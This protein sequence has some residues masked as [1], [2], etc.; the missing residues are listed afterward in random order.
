MDEE[1]AY[2]F[3]VFWSQSQSAL[4]GTKHNICDIPPMETLTESHTQPHS[5]H[6]GVT[7]RANP[8]EGVS[9]SAHTPTGVSPSDPDPARVIPEG[10]SPPL[11]ESEGVSPA[12]NIPEG[13]SPVT[14]PPKGASSFMGQSSTYLQYLS[15]I[16]YICNIESTFTSMK[17]LKGINNNQYIFQPKPH[18]S[19]H[20]GTCNTST[21]DPTLSHTFS[22]FS[23][24]PV[25]YTESSIQSFLAVDN[26]ED[27]LIQGQMLHAADSAEF[28]KVQ[29]PEICG[30]EKMGVFQY[31]S[32]SNLPARAKLL[33]SIWS[34]HRKRQPTGELLK[35]KARLCV[36][37]SQQMYGRDFW[38]TYEPVVIWSAVCFILLLTT[39]LNLKSRQVDY[40]QAFLQADL[41]DPFFMRIPQGWFISPEGTID[42]H[43]DPNFQDTSHFIKLKKNLY[44]CKQAARNWFQYLK[45][46][47]LWEGFTQSKIDP[48]LYL[49]ADCIL[50]VYT[51]DCLIF[52]PSDSIIDD[53]IKN[54][55]DT[56][57]LEDQ[58]N[59]QDYLGI[60]IT[61]NPMTKSISM[62]QAGLIE[63]VIKDVGLLTSSNT[64]MTPP[65]SILYP[66]PKAPRQDPWRYRSIIG[67][68]NLI[69]QKT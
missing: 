9:P 6:A 23:D 1:T 59:V 16:S 30:L 55:Y 19:P 52:S 45:Q 5:L 8:D 34:Y 39:V 17:R 50:V 47:L 69:A 7:P 15:A 3:K 67:K 53:L 18:P 48:C 54:L 63:S 12:I 35:Y 33:S 51:D 68:L 61:Q 27:T 4:L 41:A 57:L 60:H 58:G 64:K 10:V 38:E 40:T 37:G 43:T 2:Q 20:E 31:C 21:P 24:L 44:R 28:F 32:M 14:A 46:S 36:D 65:D 22:T 42:K 11:S 25:L 56:Y 62:T 26:K 13:V 49:T 66:D 29:T